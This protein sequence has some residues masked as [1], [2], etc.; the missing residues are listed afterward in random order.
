MWKDLNMEEMEKEAGTY[1]LYPPL[2]KK[3]LEEIIIFSRLH[4]Y[5]SE[6]KCGAVAIF[7]WIK[8]R[9]VDSRFLLP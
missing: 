1:V 2:S 4:L 5:N 8:D 6:Q 7:Q 9:R 3:E